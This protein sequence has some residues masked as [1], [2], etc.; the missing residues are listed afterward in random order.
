[1]RAAHLPELKEIRL[2]IGQGVAGTVAASGAVVNLPAAE[3]DQR[4]FRDID[5]QTGY[6][7]RS[8]LA[9]PV[10]DREGQVIGVVQVLNARR[11]RFDAAD[12]ETVSRLAADAALVIENTSLYAQLRPRGR[13]PSPDRGPAPRHRYN[14]I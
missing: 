6:R 11:G 5:R 7:T 14:R 8:V 3:Q 4:F 2:K 10:R 9:A 13:G 1:S 12:E